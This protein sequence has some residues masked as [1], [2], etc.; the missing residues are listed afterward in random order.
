MCFGNMVRSPLLFVHMRKHLSIR[1]RTGFS[2]GLKI[3]CSRGQKYV[4]H[5]PEIDVNVLIQ[6]SYGARCTNT[7]QDDAKKQTFS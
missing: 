4:H 6:V 3:R 7:I 1:T 5:T 2:P